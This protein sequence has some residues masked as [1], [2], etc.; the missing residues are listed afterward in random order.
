[1]FWSA[2]TIAFDQEQVG[3]QPFLPSICLIH[4]TAWPATCQT[5]M[6]PNVPCLLI[7]LITSPLHIT[8]L[9]SCFCSIVP[10]CLLWCS[11][12]TLSA[13]ERGNK[14]QAVLLELWG[15]N[16]W[17]VCLSLNRSAVIYQCVVKELSTV[18][19]RRA[20]ANLK[21]QGHSP[22]FTRFI[23]RQLCSV[24]YTCKQ[25]DLLQH[26]AL[27]SCQLLSCVLVTKNFFTYEV[28]SVN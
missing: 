12:Q 18:W 28:P 21:N 20:R 10:P 9:D 17:H 4:L 23:G 8:T 19:P 11:E 3:Q 2:T 13:A 6:K 24:L 14:S 26:N 1:M 5:D 25:F 15:Q 22:L 27:Q 16:W 7:F